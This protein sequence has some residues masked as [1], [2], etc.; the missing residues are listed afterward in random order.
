MIAAI[1]LTIGLIAL[2]ACTA[3]PD[4][5]V[6]TPFAIPTWV[7]PVME[8][9]EPKRPEA[10]AFALMSATGKTVSLG[11]LLD[12]RDAAVIIFYRGFF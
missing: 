11:E 1:C 2:T 3:S 4:K 6:Q 5:S 12:G 7:T 8:I 10:P 9:S